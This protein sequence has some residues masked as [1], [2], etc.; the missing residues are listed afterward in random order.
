MSYFTFQV[1]HSNLPL[2]PVSQK[3]QEPF[4]PEKPTVKLQSACLEKLT[5]KHIFYVRKAKR[6]ANFHGL[7]PCCCEDVKGIVSLQIGPNKFQDL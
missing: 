4:A 7:E 1:K 5:F 6:I 3:S 2:G